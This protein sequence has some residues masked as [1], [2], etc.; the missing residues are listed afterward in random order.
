MSLREKAHAVTLTCHAGDGVPPVLAD[1]VQIEVVLR[2]LVMN[3]IDSA[4]QANPSRGSVEVTT[5][6]NASG[7]VQVAVR[8]SGPGIRASDVDRLFESFV[9]T[10]TSGMG[11]GLS[12]SRAIVDAH[13]GRI[14]AVA[15]ATGLLYFT[16]P[17][18]EPL[19]A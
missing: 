17:P 11:M 3:A 18:D 14:W 12:I 7:E 10:R 13:G 5:A 4:T 16:P 9:T 1:P 8:D 6:V 19:S 2:N 15:G